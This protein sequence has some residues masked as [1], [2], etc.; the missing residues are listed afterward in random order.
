MR[1]GV[2]SQEVQQPVAR[3][4]GE[5]FDGQRS[6]KRFNHLR[7]IDDGRLQQLFSKRSPKLLE[8]R[9]HGILILRKQD[10]SGQRQ[11]ITM[12]SAA[13]N[14]DNDIAGSHRLSNDYLVER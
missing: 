10:L 3:D 6:L 9:V 11:A 4:M 1:C 7:Y 2:Q 14:P 12:D 13:S 8:L 5:P